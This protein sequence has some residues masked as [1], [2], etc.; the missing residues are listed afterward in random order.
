MRRALVMTLVLA[1]AAAYMFVATGA[2]EEGSSYKVRAI[3]DNAAFVIPGE[4]VKVAGVKVGSISDVDITDDF[5]AMIELDITDPAYHDFRRDAECIVRP[6]SLIGEKFVECEP[7]QVRQAGEE[8]PPELEQDEDG[9]RLLPIENTMQ[10]V[11]LD[12]INNTMRRPYRERLTIILNE[13]GIGLAG[14][15][16]DLNQVIRRANPALKELSEVLRLLSTQN[17]VLRRLAVDSDT[18]LQPLAREREHL[19]GFIANSGEVAAATA[20]RREELEASIERFPEFLRELKPTMQRLGALSDDMTPVLSDLGDVAPDINRFILELGPFSRASIPA[21]RTLGEAGEEGIPALQ[22]A[23]PII[24][25]LGRFARAVRPVAMTANAVLKS[26]QKGRG[27][28]RLWDYI[29]YQVAAVNGFDSIGHYLRAGLIVNQCSTYATVA[30]ASCTAN[31][32]GE[33]T[34]ATAAGAGS[35]ETGDP[36]LDATASILR[37]AD[38]D[39]VVSEAQQKANRRAARRFVNSEKQVDA[40]E[41]PAAAATPAPAPSATPQAEGERD[42]ALLDYLFGSDG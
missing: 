32:R 23:Q 40:P 14:R 13:L 22:A 42:A 26:F 38:P 39:D 7:T 8:P 34:T 20:E 2:G 21:L 3:F 31:F 41:Q 24:Q 19:T 25:D 1:A 5:K 12:L 33:A 28:E 36:V 15:G 6:Q 16:E 18:I 37:G 4:D 29:F 17:Q 9:A 27:I 35:Y 30:D 11:D 10:S